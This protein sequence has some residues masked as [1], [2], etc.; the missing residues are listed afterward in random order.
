MDACLVRVMKARKSTIMTSLVEEVLKLVNL[1]KP[2]LKMIKKR[3]ESLVERSYMRREEDR[4]T[5]TYIPW[6]FY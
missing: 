6:V 4:K 2:D 3:I 1:F 5:F